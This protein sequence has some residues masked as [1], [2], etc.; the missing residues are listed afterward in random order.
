MYI[1]RSALL[2]GT[3][4]VVGVGLGVGQV[5]AQGKDDEPLSA[6][7]WL[8]QSVQIPATAVV[9]RVFN[10]PPIAD[11]AETPQ[12]TMT[13]LDAPSP[14]SSGL[15]SSA[16]TGLPRSLWSASD[17]QT[18]TTLIAA[19]RVE[20]LPAM[21]E[22]MVTLMLAEADPPLG[23]G[24][25]G[26]MFLAR[27]DKLLD[28][29]ALEPAQALLE[30][31]GPDSPELFRRWFD[32]SLLTGSEDT[33]CDLLRSRPTIVT[34]YPAR[35]FCTARNGDWS[36]A[37][38]TLNTG[39]ALGDVSDEEDAVLSRFLDPELYSNDPPLPPPSRTSPLE[40]RMRAAI[41][42]GLT[43]AGLPL[44][45]SHAD[46]RTDAPWRSQIEAAER[47]ARN[48][49]ISENTLFGIYRA[50]TPSASGGVWDRAAKVQAF[51]AALRSG[52]AELIGQSLPAVWATMQAMHLE[53]AFARYYADDLANLSAP[54]PPAIGG[55]IFR[56]GLLAP[57]YEAFALAR[58]APTA[59]ERFLIAIARGD[60]AGLAT[61]D[62]AQSAILSAFARAKVPEPMAGQIAKGQL[63]EALL[64]GVAL[65]NQGLGGDLGALTD[66][67]A[68]LR[69]VGMED[70]ARRA[71]LQYLLLDRQA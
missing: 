32:V 35:I 19:E 68:L 52:D 46:L 25:D 54:T 62:P 56:I 7:D 14:D 61:T 30:E 44:A 42:E 8:S 24:P 36:A 29:G 59:D 40:F 3:A 47:L 55:L 57:K 58:V 53:V 10:E 4:L 69:A 18:L 2:A 67:L 12:I 43:T 41:G 63:G 23:A 17:T 31:A 39:R 34:T 50:Q 60:V 6:I 49:A 13:P 33:A 70:V 1:W 11:S 22:L 27:V 45:F 37:A 15:L 38:L 28:L 71:A 16:V 21:Q 48:L 26:A 66:A 9:P 65:F 5:A 20:T 64:R 51:D